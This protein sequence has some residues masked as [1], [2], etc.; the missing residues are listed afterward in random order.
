MFK[1]KNMKENKNL[2]PAYKEHDLE[3][4]NS[5]ELEDAKEIVGVSTHEEVIGRFENEEGKEK[6]ENTEKDEEIKKLK[7]KIEELKSIIENGE[8]SPDKEIGEKEIEASYTKFAKYLSEKIEDTTDNALLFNKYIIDTEPFLE[9]LYE[10]EEY[11]TK[12]K[13]PL[14]LEKFYKR[15][16]KELKTILSYREHGGYIDV[17]GLS[18]KE[19]YSE[20]IKWYTEDKENIKELNN[21]TMSDIADVFL[22]QGQVRDT[23]KLGKNIV[24]FFSDLLTPFKSK[25]L[26]GD[27]KDPEGTEEYMKKFFSLLFCKYKNKNFNDNITNILDR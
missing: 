25:S 16:E 5:G 10:T 11:K 24:L 6:L 19:C 23:L 4:K 12:N 13:I 27:L 15:F 17:E 7:S 21:E 18:V 26:Y 14:R 1:N 9:M 3:I 22:K 8:F 20:F 2:H